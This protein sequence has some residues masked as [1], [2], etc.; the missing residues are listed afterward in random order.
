MRRGSKEE[1][2]PSGEYIYI[3]IQQRLFNLEIDFTRCPES[4][5]SLFLFIPFAVCYGYYGVVIEFR[6]VLKTKN[7][8]QPTFFFCLY[9]H[10]SS[11]IEGISCAMPEGRNFPAK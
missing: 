11:S 7:R 1:E 6:F 9:Y 3:Y 4:F 10:A 5:F 2:I 8:T